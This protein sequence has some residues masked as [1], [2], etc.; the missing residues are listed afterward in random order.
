MPVVFTDYID[1]PGAPRRSVYA[2]FT[3]AYGGASLANPGDSIPIP[4]GCNLPPGYSVGLNT[5]DIAD[6]PVVSWAIEGAFLLGVNSYGS[7]VI[8]TGSV[9][10]FLYVW[11]VF[12]LNRGINYMEGLYIPGP[13]CTFTIISSLIGARFTW[14]VK[15]QGV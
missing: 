5:W 14:F 4:H 15:A 8:S 3:V 6:K 7:L 10:T 12:A 11:K 9:Y 2:D 13:S 1:T